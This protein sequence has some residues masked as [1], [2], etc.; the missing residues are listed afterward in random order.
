MSIAVSA[1]VKSS[2]LL[3]LIVGAIGLFTV[4]LAILISA[5][6]IG[7][8]PF[9]SK[10]IIVGVCVAATVTCL[11]YVFQSTKAHRIDISNIGQ[12]RLTV[13]HVY[14]R[15]HCTLLYDFL[16]NRQGRRAVDESNLNGEIVYLM[17]AST[18]WPQLLLLRLQSDNG[19]KHILCILPDCVSPESFRSLLIACRWIAAH[20]H[21]SERKIL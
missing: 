16:Q 15:L 18:L 4:S 21:A 19:R 13:Y 3:Q 2:R 6:W 5:D 8:F 1:I 14:Q 9:F 10:I 7:Y 20:S 12:I 17:D 11:F